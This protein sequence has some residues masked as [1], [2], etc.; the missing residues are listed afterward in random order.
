MQ[1]SEKNIHQILTE[2]ILAAGIK[3]SFA[4]YI[5]LK[6]SKFALMKMCHYYRFLNDQG[7]VWTLLGVYEDVYYNI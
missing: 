2:V 3:S 5:L 7:F 4:F 1:E 6:F